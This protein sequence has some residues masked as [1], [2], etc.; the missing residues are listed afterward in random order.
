MAKVNS[1]SIFSCLYTLLNECEDIRLQVLCHSKKMESLSLQ[2]L[3]M[4]ENY[5]RLGMNLPVMF[6]TDNVIGDHRFRKEVIPSLDK[7]VVPIV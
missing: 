3:E 7:D 1:L 4:M 6:Y 2:I 5:K